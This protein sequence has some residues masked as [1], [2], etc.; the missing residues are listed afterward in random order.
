MRSDTHMVHLK[1]DTTYVNGGVVEDVIH[2]A[3]TS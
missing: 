2:R 1:A 3:R